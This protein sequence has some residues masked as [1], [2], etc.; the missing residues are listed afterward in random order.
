MNFNFTPSQDSK[1]PLKDFGRNLTDEAARGKIDPVIGRDEEI[2]RIIRILSRKT[3][4][5]PILVGEPGVGKTA[6]AEGLAQKIISQDVPENLKDKEVIELDVP[7]LI[8]GAS[9]Q[10]QFEKRLKDVMNAIS[11]AKGNIIVFIDEIHTLIGTGKNQQGGMDAAQIIKPMLAKGQ[12]RLIGA[13]TLDE[14]KK[15]IESDPAFERRMQPVTI[16][17]PTIE[18]TIT[19]LRGIKE[20][21]ENYHKV[22]ISDQALVSAAN[23]SSRYISDRFLPD[24]AIDLIDE[25]AAAI[26]TQMNSKPEELEK[27]DHKKAILEMERAALA[28]EKDQK[29]LARKNQIEI[30]LKDINQKYETLNQKWSNEKESAKQLSKLREDL[31]FYKIQQVRYQNEGQYEKASVLLYKEIPDLEAKIEKII[32]KNKDKTSSLVKETVTEDDIANIVSKWTG[33]QVNKLLTDQKTKLLNLEKHLMLR[34]KGQNKALKQVGD[35]IIRAKANI[36]DPKRPLGSF[37]FMGPTGVGKTEVA[38]TLAVELFDSEKHM[39]RLDMSEY[40]EEH[41][42]ARLIGAPPGYVGYQS[43]G[44]LTEQVRKK[45]Y[46]ILLFDEIEKAHPKVLNILLQ[47]L[48][49]GHLSDSRGRKVNFK[50]TIIIMTTNIGSE[51]ILDGK[52]DKQVI[53][54]LKSYLRPEFINRVDEIIVFNTLNPSAIKLIVDNELQKLSIR[55]KEQNI[56]LD[57][58]QE[59]INK[60]AKDGYDPV[61]GA[62]PIKRYIQKNIET[63]LAQKII[64]NQI[65]PEKQYQSIV[66][67]DKIVFIEKMMN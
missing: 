35:T 36:N 49:D 58:S 21:Y 47:V 63:T 38:K 3:K 25:A 30:E 9:F 17:E 51:D 20:R 5:N 54:K 42:V 40:M 67:E 18:D 27:I 11:K 12:M 32:N 45:P 33:I 1:D 19:I 15:Y 4:N 26:Q 43:G 60:V 28:K 55:L 50:N 64:S 61:Y 59:V 31:D 10:G 29:S 56:T 65:K 22:K 2:R 53:N 14:H 48:D 13:T 66:Q 39:I 8:A 46:S 7:A 52:E 24:K 6:I 37:I 23:L 44:Q 62:R 57:F 41:S 16:N 34:V